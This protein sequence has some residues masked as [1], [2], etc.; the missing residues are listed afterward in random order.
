MNPRQDNVVIL[1]E[2]HHI[3]SCFWNRTGNKAVF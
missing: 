2:V 3:H 1:P